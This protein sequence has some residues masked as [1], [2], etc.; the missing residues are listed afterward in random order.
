MMRRF[1]YVRRSGSSASHVYARFCAFLLLAISRAGYG[2]YSI[3]NSRSQ[4]MVELSFRIGDVVGLAVVGEN[5]GTAD[6]T[7]VV[8]ILVGSIDG[9][10]DGTLVGSVDGTLDG[11]ADGSSVGFTVGSSVT[12]SRVG[13][14][15]TREVLGFGVDSAAAATL[16]I[17]S[18][19]VLLISFCCFF[20][21]E[22]TIPTIMPIRTKRAKRR[23]QQ[24]RNLRLLSC[25]LK[26]SFIWVSWKQKWDIFT[27]SSGI[28][29]TSRPPDKTLLPLTSVPTVRASSGRSLVVSFP[30]LLPKLSPSFS[31]SVRLRLKRLWLTLRDSECVGDE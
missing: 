15:V 20:F 28:S 26:S 2:E 23:R 31:P 29:A 19:M 16:P 11:Y 24:R 6:G 7:M 25:S 13:T 9:S 5:D 22:T 17:E 14:P 1:E 4:F 10:T 21:S 3:S 27:C 8:G 12:G 30:Q 18:S